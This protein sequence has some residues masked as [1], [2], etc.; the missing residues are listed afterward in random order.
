MPHAD[1]LRAAYAAYRSGDLAGILAPLDEQIEWHVPTVLPQ[2]G[3]YHGHAGVVEYLK[4]LAASL[5][6]ASVE[7]DAVLEDG[8]RVLVTGQVTSAEAS[9]GFAHSWQFADERAIRFNEYVDYELSV[10]LRKAS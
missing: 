9:Y 6:D 4:T 7:V 1:T 3:T 10:S 5:T 2:G 8:D